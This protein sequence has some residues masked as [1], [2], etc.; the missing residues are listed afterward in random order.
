MGG[1]GDAANG[2]SGESSRSAP[3]TVQI[4]TIATMTGVFIQLPHGLT[5][6]HVYRKLAC[7]KPTNAP[8]V[9]NQLPGDQMARWRVLVETD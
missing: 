9:P 7:V 4:D 6:Y 2:Q 1:I 5:N 8:P 3:Y